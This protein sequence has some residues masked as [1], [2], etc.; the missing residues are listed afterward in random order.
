MHRLTTILSTDHY[1]HASTDHYIVRINK[2]IIC[3]YQIITIPQTSIE[4]FLI[5]TFLTMG[6]KADK[7]AL[8]KKKIKLLQKI[9]FTYRN[10][11]Q[12][13]ILL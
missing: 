2:S 13:Q 4:W 5:L 11:G 1:M 12:D 8:K 7:T 3:T 9:I 6:K 10:I